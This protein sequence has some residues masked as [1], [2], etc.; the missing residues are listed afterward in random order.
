MFLPA[1]LSEGSDQRTPSVAYAA[2]SS[3]EGCDVDEKSTDGTILLIENGW[4]LSAVQDPEKSSIDFSG[5]PTDQ[6]RTEY[7]SASFFAVLLVPSVREKREC[8]YYLQV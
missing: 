5:S 4:D 8:K 6:V 3:S 2:V 7:S 1:C